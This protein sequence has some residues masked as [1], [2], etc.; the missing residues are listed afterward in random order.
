MSNQNKSD[1]TISQKMEE[2]ERIVAWF[3][4]EDFGLEEA[5]E[6]YRQAEKL[7]GEIEKQLAAVKNE[8]DVLKQKFTD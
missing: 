7:A 3:D 5:L 4:S 1:K 2:F 8:V 6:K